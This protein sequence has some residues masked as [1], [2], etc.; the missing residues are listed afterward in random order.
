MV[1]AIAF[2]ESVFTAFIR[3]IHKLGGLVLPHLECPA[4]V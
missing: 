1:T 2:A 3:F 4:D